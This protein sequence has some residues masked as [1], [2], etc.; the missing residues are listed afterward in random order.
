MTTPDELARRIASARGEEKP[1]GGR[2]PSSYSMIVR[3]AVEL[4]SA[5]AVGGLIGYFLDDWLGTS[6][7]FL[8]LCGLLGTS[9]GFVTLVR[10]H[11]SYQQRKEKSEEDEQERLDK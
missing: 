7:I 10:V 2:Q 4:L 6:P 1:S 11:N 9:A 8:T 3:L 5:V